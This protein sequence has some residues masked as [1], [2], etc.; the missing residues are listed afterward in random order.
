[1]QGYYY[2]LDQN[3]Q[4]FSFDFKEK[5]ELLEKDERTSD[6]EQI[7]E[8]LNS[9]RCM[10]FIVNIK[11]TVFGEAALCSF[12]NVRLRHPQ[13]SY[14]NP[15]AM[16]TAA[17]PLETQITILELSLSTQHLFFVT[18]PTEIMT[19]PQRLPIPLV[20]GEVSVSIFRVICLKQ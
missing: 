18:L 8:G 1:M 7:Q 5:F 4:T 2:H 15:L 14:Q 19:Y 17:S 10:M 9:G 13:S 3:S 16:Q 11:T 12:V 20:W 6:C